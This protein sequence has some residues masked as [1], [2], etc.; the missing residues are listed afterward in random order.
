MSP[1]DPV[2]PGEP[3]EAVEP[4]EPVDPRPERLRPSRTTAWADWLV[5][6]TGTFLEARSSRR[7]F[8]VGSAVTG[9]ALAV[10]GVRFATR[11]GS[12]YAAITDCGPGTLCR[13][14]YTEFCC[15]I[16]GG[17]N[18]CPEGAFAGGWWRAD[19]SVYCNGTRYYIDCHEACCGPV[20][21]DGFCGGCVAC[22][23][24]NDDCNNRKVYCSYFRYG[25]CYQEIANV[26]PIACRVVTCVPPYLTD[27]AC[28]PVAAVDNATA[29]HVTACLLNP[30]PPPPPPP[31]VISRKERTVIQVLLY[32]T[33][34]VFYVADDGALVQKAYSPGPLADANGWVTSRLTVAGRCKAGSSVDAQ[35]GYQNNFHLF[36]QA[37]DGSR[38]VH[39][40]WIRSQR[41]WVEQTH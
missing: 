30:P 11:P 2:D 26:G 16:T 31:A 41:R 17:R 14:G 34:N 36:A 21:G 40:T 27:P 18:V 12:A 22:Q 33:L 3:G 4:V 37:A 10:A 15:V 35:D 6:R 8:L 25:Q 1:V 7:G 32:G 5:R 28:A 23:C 39:L 13:D 29:D 20:R 24:A 9:S 38:L 19:Y